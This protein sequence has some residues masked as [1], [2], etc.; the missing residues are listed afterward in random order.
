MSNK[1]ILDSLFGVLNR[2]LVSTDDEAYILLAKLINFIFVL[3]LDITS[4]QNRQWNIYSRVSTI[5]EL[6]T[7]K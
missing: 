5:S 7:I 2:N 3:R 1:R 4:V 6:K